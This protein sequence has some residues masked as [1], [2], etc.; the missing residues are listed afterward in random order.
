MA[1]TNLGLPFDAEIFNYDW[2]NTPDMYLTN[3]LTSGAV[4]ADGEIANL[5]SNGS[6]FFVTPFYD[7]IG[8]EAGVYNGINDIGTDTLGGGVMAGTVYGRQKGWNVKTF[9]TDFNS[10]A[11]PMAQIVAGVANYWIKERQKAFLGILGGVFG[12]TGDA[13][14]TTHSTSTVVDSAVAP[15]DT[16][17]IGVT[18]LGDACVKACGD[19]ATDFSLAIMHSVVANRLAT[20]QLL[21]FSKYTDPSGI[22]RNLPIATV[23]GMTVVI[24]DNV[25]TTENASFSGAT[26]YSTYILGIGSVGYAS[27]SVEIPSEMKREP[28]LFGGLDAIYTRVR[29]CFQPYGFSFKGDIATDVGM[30]DATIFASASWERKMPAKSIRMVRLVTNG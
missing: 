2:K 10:N 21:E 8:G 20:L 15:D 1:E 28:A 30:P 13:D 29:E 22:T 7:L 3:M 19:S 6:N 23:N 18:S 26:D 16:N 27:A 14:W 11:D 9:I 25:P 5:I 17:K 24:N 12:I 4:V